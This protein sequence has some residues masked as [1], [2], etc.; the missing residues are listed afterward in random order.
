MQWRSQVW[1]LF[2]IRGVID[3][4]VTCRPLTELKG[5]CRRQ[6]SRQPGNHHTLRRQCGIICVASL[7]T[8]Q[9]SRASQQL[10]SHDPRYWA[11]HPRPPLLLLVCTAT[12]T[13]THGWYCG[14]PL[15]QQHPSLNSTAGAGALGGVAGPLG[16]IA[17]L[18][19]KVP[20]PCRAQTNALSLA[21]NI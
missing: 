20:L 13:Q 5:S 11:H 6:K 8:M 1:F 4:E 15:D 9:E 7:P 18:L 14:R 17:R 10:R 2:T 3:L 21:L 16:L 19:P 12:M